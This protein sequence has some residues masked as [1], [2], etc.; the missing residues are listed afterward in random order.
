MLFME[1]TKSVKCEKCRNAAQKENTK[2][3]WPLFDDVLHMTQEL[4]LVA[5]GKKLGVSDNAVRKFLKRNNGI[6]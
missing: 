5:T 6:P 2:I 4:G 1:N 3:E